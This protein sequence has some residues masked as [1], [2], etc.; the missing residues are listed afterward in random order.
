MNEDIVVP[1]V[2]FLCLFGTITGIAYLKHRR[3]MAMI[4]HGIDPAPFGETRKAPPAN[5]EAA[6]TTTGI[7]LALT[8][9]LAF[10]GLGPWLLGGL[11]PLF[12]GLARLLAILLADKPETTTAAPEDTTHG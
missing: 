3:L 1:V 7:G 8:I 6:L 11:I 2:L 12:I 9:G 5:L 4:E 10:I